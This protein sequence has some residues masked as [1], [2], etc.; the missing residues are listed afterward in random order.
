MELDATVYI[1][2]ER[3]LTLHDEWDTFFYLLDAEKTV[4]KEGSD[5]DAYVLS[6]GLTEREKEGYSYENEGY[7]IIAAWEN[8]G[9][10]K[11]KLRAIGYDGS[12][13][14]FN[15]DI[16]LDIAALLEGVDDTLDIIF[17]LSG[18]GEYE[19]LDE[20][21]NRI[22]EY[23][24]DYNATIIVT[25]GTTDVDFIK[26]SIQILYPYL[27]TYVTFL[28]M[29]F[30]PELNAE[31]IIRMAKSFAAAKMHQNIL[32]ILDN[33]SAG[34]QAVA[35]LARSQVTLPD[36][37]RVIQYPSV[38]LLLSYPTKGPQGDMSV[39]VNGR[40]GSIELYLGEDVLRIDGKNL[41]PV[42]WQG[43]MPPID[44]YQGVVMNK[45]T[46]QSNF[47]KKY[48][49]QLK[50]PNLSVDSNNWKEMDAIIQHL[51]SERAQMPVTWPTPVV[52][53]NPMPED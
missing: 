40:A 4:S 15:G 41:S 33:D 48:K 46:I 43:Y 53:D 19:S 44:A 50:D 35:G 36:N 28:D 23:Q 39:D 49:K 14:T 37:I 32:F 22:N 52:D 17:D 27:L 51:L 47:K 45:S 34:T 1:N 13:K 42:Q 25:E 24:H 38:D 18:S 12:E 10:M 9:I 8:V 30:S 21:K 20:I 3:V 11:N 26:N 6:A 29:S 16:I 5:A 2:K 31:A 7:P